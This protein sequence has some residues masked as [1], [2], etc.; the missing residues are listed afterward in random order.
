[1]KIMITS[2]QIQDHLEFRKLI[3]STPLE[4]IDFINKY[5]TL[6]KIPQKAIDHFRFTGL[7]NFDFFTTEYWR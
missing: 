4:D 5:G 7:S 3:N 2:K 1:M 6:E